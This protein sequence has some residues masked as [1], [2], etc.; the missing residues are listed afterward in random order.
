MLGAL[1]ARK[2]RKNDPGKSAG[3]TDSRP[4]RGRSKDGGRRN[5]GGGNKKH[6]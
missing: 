2:G 6:P 4:S 1:C 3:D 5:F